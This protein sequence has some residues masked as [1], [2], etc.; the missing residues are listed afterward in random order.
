MISC[1]ETLFYMKLHFFHENDD[2]HLNPLTEA[3]INFNKNSR[4]YIQVCS[5]KNTDIESK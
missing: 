3:K 2:Q 4:R 1:V 5:L